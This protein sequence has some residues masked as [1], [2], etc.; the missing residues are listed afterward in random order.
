[1]YG[2]ALRNKHGIVG[3][4]SRL[5]KE[6]YGNVRR[7]SPVWLKF[8]AGTSTSKVTSMYGPVC[9]QGY[10][11]DPRCFQKIVVWDSERICL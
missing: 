1:M 10:D 9:W 3:E 2:I 7:V 11:K 5:E 4:C 6:Y 8:F